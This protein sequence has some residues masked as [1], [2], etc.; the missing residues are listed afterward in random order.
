[1]LLPW[2]ENMVH[3]KKWLLTQWLDQ[4]M[5]KIGRCQ[6]DEKTANLTT[7]HGILVNSSWNL[8]LAFQTLGNVIEPWRLGIPSVSFHFGPL[9]P[10]FDNSKQL[11]PR[12]RL[13]TP[14]A[15]PQQLQL[16]VINLD[17]SPFLMGKYQSYQIVGV[18]HWS[19][20]FPL[21]SRGQ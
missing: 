19:N 5:P 18:L 8:G 20:A 17:Y 1:M 10:W 3:Q 13:G 6:P 12:G 21:V 14:H 11:T 15:W 7:T 16:I 4:I 2:W 9:K